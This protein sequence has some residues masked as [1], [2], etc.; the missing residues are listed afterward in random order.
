M[1][2]VVCPGERNA[3]GLM[4]WASMIIAILSILITAVSVRVAVEARRASD[5]AADAAEKS[6]DESRR[7]NDITVL[8]KDPYWTLISEPEPE[9]GYA[10]GPTTELRLTNRGESPGRDVRISFD[11]DP[12][13]IHI[14]PQAW[15][16]IDRGEHVTF[17][18]LFEL[19]PFS[20][21]GTL[22]NNQIANN[23]DRNMATV[24][25]T[26]PA[27]E[28]KTQRVQLP[29]CGRYLTEAESSN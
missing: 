25:W 8:Y 5:R 15:P 26:S 13:H 3:G 29:Q 1:L 24:S 16:F 28:N 21:G 7:A 10:G 27:G 18:T 9:G 6:A 2:R 11:F 12:T 20:A 4:D 19:R 23:P 22:W 14:P 17:I